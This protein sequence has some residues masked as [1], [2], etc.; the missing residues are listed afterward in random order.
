MFLE[1]YLQK[2]A[3]QILTSLFMQVIPLIQKSTFP[4]HLNLSLSYD[5]L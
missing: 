5:S 3:S 4:L 2:S 1:Y